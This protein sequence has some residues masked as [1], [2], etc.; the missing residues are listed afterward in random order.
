MSDIVRFFKHLNNSQSGLIAYGKVNAFL[1]SCFILNLIVYDQ[2]NIFKS[3]HDVTQLKMSHFSPSQ[4]RN[5]ILL[6]LT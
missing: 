2:K 1:Y 6:M 3:F 5:T 4:F